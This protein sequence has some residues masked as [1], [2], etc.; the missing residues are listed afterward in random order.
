[1]MPRNTATERRRHN[2][3]TAQWL[4]ARPAAVAALRELRSQ[5]STNTLIIG[6]E[7]LAPLSHFATRAA[8]PLRMAPSSASFSSIIASLW[9]ASTRVSAHALDTSTPEQPGHFFQRE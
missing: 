3:V 6:H 5:S 8:N 9:A 7:R 1:M 2:A 4:D